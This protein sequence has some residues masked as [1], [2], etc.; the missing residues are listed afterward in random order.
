MGGLLYL[1][2]RVAVYS[3]FFFVWGLLGL[4]SYRYF[5]MVF[6]SG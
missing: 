3:I 2:V 1:I 5:G 4:E 6:L